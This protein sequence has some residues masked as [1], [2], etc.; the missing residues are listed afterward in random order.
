[1]PQ[2][3]TI[4]QVAKATEMTKH[5]IGAWISRGYFK[6]T[7]EVEPGK[8]RVFTI[9]DA[10]RLGAAIELVRVGMDPIEAA[11]ATQVIHGL[12]DDVAFLVVSQGPV[13]V[14]TIKLPDGSSGIAY[15]PDMPMKRR[16]IVG[17][18]QLTEILLD[19]DKRSCAIVNIDGVEKRVRAALETDA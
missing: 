2:T 17:S 3:L 10:I 12:N 18:R 6:P 15:N 8:A 19:P 16:K 5:Q 1:M 9:T 7:N 14:P 4:H 11:V 13:V